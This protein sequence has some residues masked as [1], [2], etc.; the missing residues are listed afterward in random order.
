MKHFTFSSLLIIFLTSCNT[1]T[2]IVDIQKPARISISNNINDVVIANRSTPSRKNLGENIME[3][4]FTGEGIGMDKKAS[5]M[6]ANTL[7]KSLSESNRFK[8]K[9]SVEIEFKGTGTSSFSPPLKW[10]KISNICSSYNAD[11]LIVLEAFDSN[12][13]IYYGKP[14]TKIR[15]EKKKKI[16]E[17]RFPAILEIE[18]K[19]GWRIYDLENKNI[20]DENI[21]TEIK[22]FKA[23][24]NSIKEAKRNL[25]SLS[26]ALIESGN[27]AGKQYS[28]RISP[29]WIRS[30]RVFYTGK[31][32]EL[33]K[34]KKLVKDKKWDKAILIWKGLINNEDDKLASQACY[35]L[36][37]ASEIK[38][39]FVVALDWARKAKK[40]GDKKS[41]SYI[42]TL[43]N[44]IVDQKKLVNQLKK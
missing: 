42:R 31:Y 5:K 9:N 25:P 18:I 23:W 14:I 28:N 44:R 16:K 17:L 36:A 6:C 43:N 30:S 24:G 35:N 33:K 27:F 20:I 40:L 11:A 4:V 8:V 22:E 32:D 7:I 37:V 39:L 15:K 41:V 19:S 26:Y 12:T 1:T 21:F 3:G 34:A 38:G 13:R 10:K 29:N 2:L